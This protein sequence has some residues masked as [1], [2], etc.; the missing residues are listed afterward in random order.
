M[1]SQTILIILIGIM[2]SNT[3]IV[4]NEYADHEFVLGASLLV[5][6]INL[7]VPLKEVSPNILLFN[8]LTQCS[9]VIIFYYELF[10]R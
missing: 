10:N 5:L 6:T 8:I 4:R 1:L 9:V 3:Q 2:W 7:L